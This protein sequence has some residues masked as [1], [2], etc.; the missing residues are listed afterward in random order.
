MSDQMRR[1]LISGLALA[2]VA[3]AAYVFT[4]RYYA[5][6]VPVPLSRIELIYDAGRDAVA[7]DMTPK[8]TI[9]FPSAS[10]TTEA[11]LRGGL[12]FIRAMS[13]TAATNGQTR[14]EGIDFAG[15]VKQLDYRAMYCTDAT[16]LFMLM[17][18]SQGLPS[19]EWWLWSSDNYDGGSAHS[20]A[21]FYNPALGRWQVVDALTSTVIRDASGKPLSMADTLRAFK[22]GR[23]DSLIFDKSP[24]MAGI[25]S[26]SYDTKYLLTVNP[27][28][29]LSLKPP[30]WFASVPKT[31]LLIGVPVLIGN[32]RHDV[33]VFSTKIVFVFGFLCALA[34]A[35]LYFR[36]RRARGRQG[37][38]A[39]T[40]A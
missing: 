33:R 10:L 6:M 11:G 38:L 4:Y 14:Y 16:Q 40:P 1:I 24:A 32:G 36:N 5:R 12:D 27:T 17:A 3:S 30:R 26:L 2:T 31:D 37:D 8:G 9:A 21:E 25:K 13:P 23:Q 28:P 18:H 22:A 35:I 19:R 34:A 29:V 39:N 7:P 20:V 15:W